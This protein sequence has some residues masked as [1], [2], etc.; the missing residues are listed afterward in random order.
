MSKRE[1]RRVEVLARVAGGELKLTDAAI[2]L[3][4]S[5]RQVK[6]MWRCYQED[7]PGGL[8]HGN[9][10]KESNRA[11]PKKFR[12]RVLRLAKWVSD[13]DQRWHPSTWRE[14]TT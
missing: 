3:R 4:K 6:R 11:K 12:E 13:S 9:A 5:Y 10:G 8:K 14:R 1:L 2:L 7:G